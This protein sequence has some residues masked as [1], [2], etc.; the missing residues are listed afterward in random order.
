MARDNY[1]AV[2]WT[3]KQLKGTGVFFFDVLSFALQYTVL[4]PFLLVCMRVVNM[5]LCMHVSVGSHVSAC[6][7]VLACEDLRPMLEVF[8]AGSTLFIQMGILSQI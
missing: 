1:V 4:F 5:C 6:M 8:L 3:L 2:V 7:N